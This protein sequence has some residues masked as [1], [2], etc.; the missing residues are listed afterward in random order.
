M[1]DQII[2]L[3]E[4]Y[5]GCIQ[6]CFS[7]FVVADNYLIDQ[8]LLFCYSRYASTNFL[9]ISQKDLYSLDLMVLYLESDKEVLILDR[10][11]DNGKI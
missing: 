10:N 2:S 11:G 3:F 8:K 1:C 6:I 7:P 9:L 4:V 5:P